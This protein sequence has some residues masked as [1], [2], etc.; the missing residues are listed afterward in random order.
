M[1]TREIRLVDGRML[2]IEES[3]PPG[4]PVLLF[5]HGTPGSVHQRR[6]LRSAVH[7]RGWRLVTY[8]RA[9]YGRSTRH[10]GRSV[11]DVV[12][13]MHG[14]LD[15]VDA[16]H[17]MVAGG[18]GGGPHALACAALMPERVRA[19]QTVAGAGAYGLDLDFLAGMGED[20]LAEFGAALSGEAALREFL[21]PEAVQIRTA[22]PA[23]LVE[24]LST[25]LPEVDRA[26]LTGELGEDTVRG[27]Q[28]GI[29]TSVDGWIDDDL[30]FTRA[31]GFDLATIRV[32]VSIWQGD[33]DLMVPFAHG[34]WLAGRLPGAR[35][36]LEPGQGHLSITVGAVERMLDELA[37]LA[38]V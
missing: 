33:A 38:Q 10:R 19:V 32:P 4:G 35:V 9:G 23:E 34:Q 30:A 28:Y 3:G 18:S 1:G 6:F 22:T 37:E 15:A 17:A 8:S 2:E 20:N 24:V 14:V 21:E 25:V 29:G 12:P 7:A 36:H 11:A 27:L 26:V 5:H 13:D 31:W 16:E